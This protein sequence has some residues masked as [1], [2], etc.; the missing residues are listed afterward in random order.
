MIKY[1]RE[2]ERSVN[3]TTHSGQPGEDTASSLADTPSDTVTYLCQKDT[4]CSQ[5]KPEMGN[6]EWISLLLTEIRNTRGAATESAEPTTRTVKNTRS[7]DSFFKKS[8]SV[9]NESSSSTATLVPQ[10]SNLTLFS[11]IQGRNYNAEDY[12]S[13]GTVTHTILNSNST[14]IGN[15][16]D[17]LDSLD[18]FNTD[19]KC[20]KKI[21]TL[22]RDISLT[23]SE[24]SPAIL[25]TGNLNDTQDM[26][27]LEHLAALELD[28]SIPLP[29]IALPPRSTRERRRQRRRKSG[30][31]YTISSDSDEHIT[32]TPD[33][34]SRKFAIPLRKYSVSDL[35]QK[36]GEDGEIL[37]DE[38]T[39]QCHKK[40]Q[41]PSERRRGH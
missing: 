21:K 31:T 18:D 19:G 5:T 6:A 33:N 29:T 12:I 16:M 30:S 40:L 11:K 37:G 15:S 3:P 17:K 1:P 38:I 39:L 8:S 10:N 25:K 7:M 41:M 13:N 2:R 34:I 32:P 36:K 24:S 4:S 26:E 20:P 27:N 35:L 22:H 28:N 14:I 23:C 9:T